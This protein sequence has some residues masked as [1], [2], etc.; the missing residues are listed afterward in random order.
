MLTRYLIYTKELT[1]QERESLRQA[2]IDSSWT[3]SENYVEN[4]FDVCLEP[5]VSIDILGPIIKKCA[6]LKL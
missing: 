5:S 2:I 3:Y 4:Y 1:I 6:V